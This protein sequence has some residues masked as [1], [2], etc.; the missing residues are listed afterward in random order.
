[1]AIA[2]QSLEI[3]FGYLG[4]YSV[5]KKNIF[6]FYVISTVF[7]ILMFWSVGKIAAILPILTTGIRY[8]IFI[9]KDDYK[10]KIPLYFCLFLHT[11]AL[12]LS[13]HSFVDVIPSALVII[14]CFIY[15]YLDGAKL[16]GSIF[17]INIP[18][19]IYYIFCGLYLTT[20]NATIQTILVGLAYLKL[21]NNKPVK[22]RTYH[23]G[24][25]R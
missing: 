6:T 9:F 11:V 15:W 7:S 3:F 8:F 13:T 12:I 1:M 25:K 17:I 22:E 16:K 18:W 21:K 14:G 20:V 4:A 10:T 24:E 23:R 19:I 5:K 2:F